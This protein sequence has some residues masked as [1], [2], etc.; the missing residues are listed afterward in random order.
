MWAQSVRSL[1]EAKVLQTSTSHDS[2]S[3]AVSSTKQIQAAQKRRR[4]SVQI[5][6]LLTSAVLLM[7]ACGTDSDTVGDAQVQTATETTA[8]TT[9][10]AAA[11]ETAPDTETASQAETIA[12]AAPEPNADT[13]AVATAD[14][15]TV[16]APLFDPAS[17]DAASLLA[18]AAA[19]TQGSVRGVVTLAQG[20]GGELSANFQAS[21][22]GDVAA[23]MELAAGI[24]PGFPD[25]AVAEVRYVGDS[26]Y[27]RPPLSPEMTAQFGG[28]EVWYRNE[29]V[30]GS[31]P[32]AALPASEITCVIALVADASTGDCDPLGEVN[33]LLA[34]ASQAEIVAREE[35]RGVASNKVRF[36]LPLMGLLED[37]LGQETGG[38]TAL[39][40]GNFDT[41]DSEGFSGDDFGSDGFPSDD[42]GSDGFGG[43]FDMLDAGLEVDA[44]IDDYGLVRRLSYDLGA[45]FS[46]LGIPEDEIANFGISAEFFDYGADISVTA[47][48]NELLV[49][50]G[51]MEDFLPN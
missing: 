7:A 28:A 14:A 8:A 12:A 24:D 42:F 30:G 2:P 6:A 26:V 10:T 33:R 9:T 50:R 11:A 3:R 37:A 16:G 15:S 19:Q 36:T 18:L 49:E 22:A 47:P 20:P 41:G 45:A 31:L 34:A 27:V 17:G 48:P 35:T 21:A 29:S 32:D 25:G 40:E 44:W 1:E 46:N 38:E 51:R 5:V 13:E 4:I 39:P 43:F 23:R